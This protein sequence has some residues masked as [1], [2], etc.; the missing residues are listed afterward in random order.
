MLLTLTISLILA[1][2]L[3][4]QLRLETLVLKVGGTVTGEIIDVSDSAFVVARKVGKSAI[5]QTIKFSQVSPN[6]MYAS[7]VSVLS[8]LDRTDHDRVAR[9]SFDAGLH[10]IARRHW[11]AT[12]PEG[13]AATGD[14]L[15]NINRCVAKDI[16]QLL[17]RSRKALKLEQFSRAR[18]LAMTAMRRYAKH[19]AVKNMPAYLN[20]ITKS[21]E[22]ARRRNAAIARSAR[23]KRAWERGERYIQD[24]SNWVEKALHAESKGLKATERFR[25]ARSRLDTATKYLRS[26]EKQAS[27]LRQSSKIPRELWPQLA[28]IEEDIVALQVRM[29]LHVASLYTV[30][31]SYGT[32]LAYVNTA[33]SYDPSNEQALA[34]RARIEEAAAVSSV[35][36]FRGAR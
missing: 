8:P 22:S 13:K 16:E 18:R 21:Y 2:V 26:A 30:R 28:K 31:G 5:K 34:A 32:A 3:Q 15:E 1:S 11:L 17:K 23:A 33:L 35:R 6:S 9:L 25:V 19:D 10:A 36:P 24:V 20:S 27:K 14:V 12:L 29:R 7:L 4:A